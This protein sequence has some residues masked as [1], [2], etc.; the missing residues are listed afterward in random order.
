VVCQ[1]D[2]PAGRGLGL[3]EPP[4]KTAARELGLE[5]HQPVKVKTGNLD[6]WLRQRN[7][8]AAVVLAY[9]RILPRPAL[10]TPRAGFFNLHAS[11]LP[12]Y[13]GAAPI[14]WAIVHGETVTGMS[15]M[16]MEEQLDTGPVFKT[17]SIDIAPDATAGDLGDAMARLAALMV[18]EDLPRVLRGELPAVAQDHA[19]A[20]WAPPIREEHRR[21]DWNRT[22]PSICN[23][24]RGMMPA[25]SAFTT[26]RGKRLKV[27][28]A[29]AA[30]AVA[31]GSPGEAVVLPGHRVLVRCADTAIELLVA[32][33]EGGRALPAADLL[34]GRLLRPGD[35]LGE[36]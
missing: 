25:P 11:L 18:R 13:R 22:A 5:V 28:S 9:G 10:E 4:V 36:A 15:L 34:N 29:R 6:E 31:P 21:I 24:V 1:P 20:T 26:V 14:H 27:L 12:K 32:Q 30:E 2:R 35:R 17:R 23:L 7:P 33:V 3:H 8:D 19:S 16:R